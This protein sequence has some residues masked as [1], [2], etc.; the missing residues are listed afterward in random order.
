MSPK[1][2]WLLS[3]LVVCAYPATASTYYVGTCK[4]GSFSTISAALNS[5]N[6][7]PGIDDYDMCLSVHRTGNYLEGFDAQGAQ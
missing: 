5:P 7:A 3:V 2:V 6:V 1:T 4:S